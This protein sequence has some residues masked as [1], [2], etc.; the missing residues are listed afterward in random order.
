MVGL[1]SDVLPC[2]IC[3]TL[4]IIVDFWRFQ[5]CQIA[6]ISSIVGPSITTIQLSLVYVS[7]GINF[8][9]IS[10]IIIIMLFDISFIQ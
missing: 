8:V 1:A 10:F 4:S 2:T 9:F 3:D 7:V 5:S 6:A